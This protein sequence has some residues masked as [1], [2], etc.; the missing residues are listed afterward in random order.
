[1][2]LEPSWVVKLETKGE[3]KGKKGGYGV[4][5]DS[6]Q[7]AEGSS[8]AIRIDFDFSGETGKDSHAKTI[9]RKKRDLTLY[10]GVEF[11][12]R[13][14]DDLLGQFYVL[15]SQPD[16]L[17]KMD[18][19]TGLFEIDQNWKKVLISFGE[20]LIARGWIKRGAKKQGAAPG[21][22]IIR[23]N[24][25]EEIQFRLASGRNKSTA[26]SMWIDQISFYSD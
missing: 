16:D 26:G 2:R 15:T 14:T 10:N 11:Y 6:A 13:G 3:K 7:G 23:P 9:N 25:L 1:L 18:L 22:Q 21:D 12:A 4:Y 17:Q 20:L 19:W 8:G 24:R 5:L